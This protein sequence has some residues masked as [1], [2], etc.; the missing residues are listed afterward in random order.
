MRPGREIPVPNVAV[1]RRNPLDRGIPVVSAADD[2]RAHDHNR[3]NRIDAGE[4]DDRKPSLGVKEDVAPVPLRAPD[5]T[6]AP[7]KTTSR[8]LPRFEICC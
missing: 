8:L 4:L 1:G 6:T 7:G 5:V 3:T 2:L